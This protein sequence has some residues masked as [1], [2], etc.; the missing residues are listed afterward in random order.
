MLETNNSSLAVIERP[1]SADRTPAT[2]NSAI[3]L[4]NESFP[5]K[6]VLTP[7]EKLS[8]ALYKALS[9]KSLSSGDMNINTAEA[10]L[11]ISGSA[12]PK[13]LKSAYKALLIS[14]H[15]DNFPTAN[16]DQKALLTTAAQECGRAY[17]TLLS[18]GSI[19]N[20]TDKR[21]N[22][23]LILAA[24]EGSVPVSLTD[25]DNKPATKTIEAAKEIVTSTVP[26]A[27]TGTDSSTTLGPIVPI[28][29][30]I[31]DLLPKGG[32]GEVYLGGT[33]QRSALIQA[34]KEAL[35]ELDTKDSMHLNAQNKIE[36][37][38][39]TKQQQE[40]VADHDEQI[41][42]AIRLHGAN[43]IVSTN[44]LDSSTKEEP[45]EGM[46]ARTK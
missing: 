2:D 9:I 46:F 18:N 40:V 41:R 4:A 14:L 36:P 33:P 38:A 12:T 27:A 44:G 30:R 28:E 8:D 31:N 19:G 45:K 1:T 39:A 24:A 43:K 34:I 15:T 32:K 16:G 25:Y 42:Q 10:I 26:A 29:V 37:K 35:E 22:N 20:G 3:N 13:E 7:E 23:S 11:G 6:T 21:G 17:E 5:D